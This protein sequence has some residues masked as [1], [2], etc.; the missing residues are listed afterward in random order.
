MSK[1]RKTPNPRIEKVQ[2]QLAQIREVVNSPQ[3]TI[4]REFAEI[5][6]REL[7]LLCL[8]EPKKSEQRLA[9]I[10]ALIDLLEGFQAE[11]A[12]IEKWL[13]LS[14]LEED[15]AHRDQFVQQGNMPRPYRE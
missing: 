1:K 10:K 5:Q 2:Q 8:A 15:A 13:S 9:E 14:A 12:Q 11:S 6:L 7:F 3:W 4:F